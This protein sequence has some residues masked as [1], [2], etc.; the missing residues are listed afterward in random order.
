M[1]IWLTVL[2]VFAGG[3]LVFFFRR[4][5]S[6]DPVDQREV[7]EVQI[8]P[9]TR[10]EVEKEDFERLTLRCDILDRRFS[11]A[12]S[13]VRTCDEHAELS[14][15][16]ALRLAE[17]LR[18]DGAESM[19]EGLAGLTRAK[20][21]IPKGEEERAV[22][23]IILDGVAD[24]VDRL[25]ALVR[26]W[27][28]VLPSLSSGLRA[29][30][31]PLHCGAMG[32]RDDLEL[33]FR[34][35]AADGVDVVED[36]GK[37]Q[38]L[39]NAFVAYDPADYGEP[40]EALAALFKQL[41]LLDHL[42]LS[43]G[44]RAQLRDRVVY[45]RTTQV[46]DDLATVRDRLDAEK[47]PPVIEHRADGARISWRAVDRLCRELESGLNDARGMVINVRAVCAYADMDLSRALARVSTLEAIL[48]RIE[49]DILNITS[50]VCGEDRSGTKG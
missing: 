47:R 22:A 21:L 14:T 23:E 49:H 31:I 46:T 24:R 25:E 38:R 44:S 5:R 3:T 45:F 28:H 1:T 9:R 34:Q 29:Q 42:A 41:G 40:L 43:V 6:R 18:R 2:V 19:E 20:V 12:V 39:K 11:A 50:A 7:R 27:E 10:E 13:D 8:A 16:F 17:M 15:G 32:Y 36:L 33:T 37:V 26:G 4:R 48:I 30:L 35:F